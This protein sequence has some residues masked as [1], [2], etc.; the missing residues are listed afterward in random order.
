MR[1]A[2][3]DDTGVV[4]IRT[5]TIEEAPLIALLGAHVQRMH[6]ENRP[7]WFTPA[8]ET[9]T[10]DWYREMLM[11]PA[12]TIYLAEDDDEA[13][14]YVIAVVHQRPDTPF[15][16]AQTLLEVDQIGVTPS[17]R[18][19]GVGHAL[20]NAVRALADQ[21]SA[22]RIVLTTWSFNVEAHR[23]FEA[24]GLAPELNRMTMAW[25]A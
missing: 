14:G 1:E 16:R 20:F 6:H 8:D 24:E 5:A 9:A 13:L 21:V 23:F 11:N 15:G 3:R 18:R 17:Q 10:V 25:P 4:K 22:D 2:T 12:A 7:D 19:R